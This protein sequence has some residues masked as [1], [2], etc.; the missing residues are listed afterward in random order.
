M[1]VIRRSIDSDILGCK[2]LVTPER[3]CTI[4]SCLVL[5]SDGHGNKAI[6][7]IF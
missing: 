5:R 6:W 1:V 7:E 2:E 3:S 4:I